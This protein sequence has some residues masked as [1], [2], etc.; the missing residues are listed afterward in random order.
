MGCMA[1]FTFPVTIWID[2]YVM[3]PVIAPESGTADSKP[4]AAMS[5][6]VKVL[7]ALFLV[8]LLFSLGS[9]IA[10]LYV[11]GNALTSHLSYAP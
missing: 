6:E 5:A 9:A 7:F 4:T 8:F 2:R 1:I 3:G 10:T 11:G